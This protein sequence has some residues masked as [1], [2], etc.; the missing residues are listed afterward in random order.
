[1]IALPSTSSQGNNSLVFI[2]SE[3]LDFQHGGN[4]FYSCVLLISLIHPH[5]S[6]RNALENYTGTLIET[7][8]LKTNSKDI[9]TY[10]IVSCE[11]W[12]LMFRLRKQDPHA[13][14]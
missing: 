1:M 13:N 6:E 8:V 14:I 12:S 11:I 3:F 10:F 2:I 9:G 4:N 5:A 7:V